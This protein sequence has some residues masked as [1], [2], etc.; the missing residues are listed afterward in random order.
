MILCQ[1]FGLIG[2]VSKDVILAPRNEHVLC[3]TC[4]LIA[5]SITE[6]E[7]QQAQD[8]S[9]VPDWRYIVDQGL[10]HRGI[11]AQE[12]AAT[13]MATMSSLT[14]CSALIQR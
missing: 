11:N 3:A 8:Q 10:R 13:A 5:V 2:H 12:A 14:D 6:R 4:S 1:I 7:A 9:P